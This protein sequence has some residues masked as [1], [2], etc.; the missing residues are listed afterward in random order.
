MEARFRIA[1]HPSFTS[2]LVG[3]DTGR[4]VQG[5][6]RDEQGEWKTRAAPES[7]A[8]G[9]FAL[10]VGAL[11]DTVLS[12]ASSSGV[13]AHLEGF[14]EGFIFRG[15]V[16]SSD[17]SHRRFDASICPSAISTAAARGAASHALASG[18]EW[19][20][21]RTNRPAHRM[22][23]RTGPACH[24]RGTRAGS[25]ALA[26]PISTNRSQCL[27][28]EG[29]DAGDPRLRD[30]G[31]SLS[32]DR[33]SAVQGEVLSR[34]PIAASIASPRLSPRCNSPNARCT[35]FPSRSTR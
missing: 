2:S 13:L 29:A 23:G 8:R 25:S 28:F 9:P 18:L 11:S 35:I 31:R 34:S 30:S 10:D 6:V 7:G 16:Q 20:C 33:E 5:E 19:P 15:L 27:N 32:A 12:A 14:S 22:V 4:A 1:L 24:A 17:T 3:R 21:P 26:E